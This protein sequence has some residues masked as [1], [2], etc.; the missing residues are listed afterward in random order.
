[1]KWLSRK[2][3]LAIVAGIVVLFRPELAW[4][5]VS[6]YAIHNAANIAEYIWKK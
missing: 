6:L 4:P 2:V 1:M 5:I 3:A